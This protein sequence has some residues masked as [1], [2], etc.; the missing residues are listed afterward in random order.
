MNCA[1]QQQQLGATCCY[2]S[3]TLSAA[4]HLPDIALR[5]SCLTF[6][7][8]R[9]LTPLQVSQEPVSRRDDCSSIPLPSRTPQLTAS[10][11]SV[12]VAPLH[13][14][15][16]PLI[17]CR[18]PAT[19]AWRIQ[20]CRL[21]TG[22]FLRT[23]WGGMQLWMTQLWPGPGLPC[24]CWAALPSWLWDPLHASPQITLLYGPCKT[25]QGLAPLAVVVVN[26][27]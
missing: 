27:R 6:E 20:Y 15:F 12:P 2:R 24:S 3:Q 11:V 17:R 16:Y 13:L 8:G 4:S 23:W 19:T 18:T 26:K 10:S 25:C 7:A 21:C 1:Q 22:P 5:A 9:P 14:I